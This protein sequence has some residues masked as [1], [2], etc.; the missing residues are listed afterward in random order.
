[1]SGND[2][3][4][5]IEPCDEFTTKFSPY[6]NLAKELFNRSAKDLRSKFH[7]SSALYWF[8]DT[9]SDG[10]CSIKNISHWLG[11]APEQLFD[12]ARGKG[13][14]R[15]TFT[16]NRGRNDDCD[17]G[18]HPR[19]KA[20]MGAVAKHDCSFPMCTRQT[21]KGYCHRHSAT[22]SERKCKFIA[23]HKRQPP[24]SYLH[25]P[26]QPRGRR[27]KRLEEIYYDT[28]GVMP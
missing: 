15:T 7:Q 1:M 17:N 13:G 4:C 28:Y 27:T 25:L 19:K 6:I 18:K 2:A 21:A 14:C 11:L 9:K 12:K 22:V 5:P 10:P 16:I 26:I 24:I 20:G 8:K 3:W 23:E